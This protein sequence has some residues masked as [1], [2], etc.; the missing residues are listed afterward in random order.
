MGYITEIKKQ[1]AP[2]ITASSEFHNKKADLTKVS[3][4]FE[5]PQSAENTNELAWLPTLL[6][7]IS[8]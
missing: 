3:R 1:N 6:N 2:S 8:V 4:V 7:A 5:N